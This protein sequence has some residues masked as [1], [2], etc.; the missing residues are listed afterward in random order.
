[1]ALDGG[2]VWARRSAH[3][4]S[5]GAER[6]FQTRWELIRSPHGSF[7]VRRMAAFERWLALPASALAQPFKSVSRRTDL[8]LSSPERRVRARGVGPGRVAKVC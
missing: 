7:R 2:V 6:A 3:G 5:E 8:A 1:M 4:C